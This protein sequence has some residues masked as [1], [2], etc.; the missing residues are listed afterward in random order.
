MQVKGKENIYY[1]Y[2]KS[3]KTGEFILMSDKLNLKTIV[4]DKEK[5]LIMIKWAVYQEVKKVFNMYILNKR[6]NFKNQKLIGIH[7]PTDHHNSNQ[8]L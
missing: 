3:K 7:L 6:T 2:S 8:R 4:R 1:V 5:Q